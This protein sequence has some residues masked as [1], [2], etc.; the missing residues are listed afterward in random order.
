LPCHA[1]H[2]RPGMEFESV[3]ERSLADIWR[4]SP[5]FAAFRGE[6]WMPE[7]CRSCD[8][9]TLDFGGRRRPADSLTGHDGGPA[10]ATDTVC[11]LSPD[12]GLIEAARQAAEETRPVPLVY[13]TS[14]IPESARPS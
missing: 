3:T 2:T 12:H 7:P 4:D 13:R 8:R 10:A 1:A 11:R 14:R 9:R 5:G 6:E